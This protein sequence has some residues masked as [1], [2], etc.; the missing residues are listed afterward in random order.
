[1]ILEDKAAAMESAGREEA[2]KTNE[3]ALEAY[4]ESLSREPVQEEA[5][6]NAGFFFVRRR[7]YR[8]ARECFTDYIALSE[9]EEK[10]ERAQALL[11]DIES[12]VLD[13]NDFY[14]AVNL[15]RSG[16]DDLSLLKIKNF[17]EKHPR[18]WNGWFVLGWA[19]RRLRRWEDGYEAFKKAIEFGGGNSDTRNEAAICLMEMGDL[20]EARKELEYALREEPENTK[21]ISNL[22]VLALKSGDDDEAA[23]FFRAVLELDPNDPVAAEFLRDR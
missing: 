23:A 1:V 7:E 4:E 21:I 8:R 19:L 20:T 17:L 5:L 6:F 9:D 14:D 2:E 10:R 18:V 15:V 12:G 11:Y 3:L 22:G 16:K 13:D